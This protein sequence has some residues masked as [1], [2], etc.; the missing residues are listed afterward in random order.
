MSETSRRPPSAASVRTSPRRAALAALTAVP[1]V[2][3]LAL[4]Q[5]T[6]HLVE[7]RMTL[8]ERI[9]V[10]GSA[11]QWHFIKNSGVAF[12][13]GENSTLL[14]TL[15]AACITVFVLVIAVRSRQRAW[16]FAAGLVLGG[17][18]GNLVD[19]LFR[20]P[21]AGRGHVVDFIGVG[22]FPRF[23][24][25]DSAVCIGVALAVLLLLRGIDP[26]PARPGSAPAEE[27]AEESAEERADEKAEEKA[28]EEKEQA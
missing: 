27:T 28:K 11:V 19:R 20:E 23:N 8:G 22:T 16:S 18:V 7:S 4:D 3:V 5:L 25:A 1:A 15:V 17:A 24:V 26:W 12:S 2:L 6:K 9:D 13:L 14:A 21:G 10:I